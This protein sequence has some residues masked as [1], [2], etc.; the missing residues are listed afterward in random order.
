MTAH[1]PNRLTPEA[2]PP[3]AWGAHLRDLRTQRDLSLAALG[4]LVHQNASYLGKIERG[5]RPIP[6]ALAERCDTALEAGGALI[7]SCLSPAG[8]AH[9]NRRGQASDEANTGRHVANPAGA[10]ANASP[11]VAFP[12]PHPAPWAP[13]EDVVV[14]ALTADGKVIF[15]AVT[16]RSLLQSLGAVIAAGSAASALPAA[17]VPAAPSATTEFVGGNPVEHFAQ[18]RHV[19]V[20]SDNLAGAHRVLPTV[21]EQLQIMQR[22]RTGL[23]GADNRALL[24]LQTQ[25]AEFAGW[26]LQDIGDTTAAHRW[27]DRALQW[28][29]MTDEPDLTAYVLARKSQLAADTDDGSEAVD[30]AS[31]AIGKAGRGTRLA[32]VAATYAAHGHA[33]LGDRAACD[34]GYE[35]ARTLLHDTDPDQTGWWGSW[36]SQD[37]LDVHRARSL[38]TLGRFQDSADLY[39][40]TIGALPSAYRRDHGVYLARHSRALAGARDVEHAVAVA[41]QALSIGTQTR[42]GRTLTELS[43]LDALLSRQPTNPHARRLH[44]ALRATVPTSRSPRQENPA[45]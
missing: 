32:A 3:H 5:E 43:R 31:A 26:L 6:T 28:A 9:D 14:P 21:L 1:Q 29:C 40:R 16:R 10:V 44:D 22:V 15:V 41:L 27:T 33:M 35:Q 25:Y 11:I 45:P 8:P 13:D 37:Y 4:R 39:D 7:R 12:S 17:I 19:L 34:R 24:R 30:V 42:S 38:A 23:Q 2:D 18:V 36:F 20:D